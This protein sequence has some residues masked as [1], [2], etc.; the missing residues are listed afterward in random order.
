MYLVEDRFGSLYLTDAN[1]REVIT[2]L[3]EPA[4]SFSHHDGYKL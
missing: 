3:V 4:I 2:E 1:T